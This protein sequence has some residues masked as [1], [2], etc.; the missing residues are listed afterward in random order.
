MTVAEVAEIIEKNKS[1]QPLGDDP[2]HLSPDYS[3][4][5]SVILA[6]DMWSFTQHEVQK[7]FLNFQLAVV[8]D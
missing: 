3:N 7:G 6:L 5:V 4:R 2:L 8:F 1:H